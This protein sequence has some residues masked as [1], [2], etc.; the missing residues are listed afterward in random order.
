MPNPEPTQPCLLTIGTCNRRA[1]ITVLVESFLKHHPSAR[2]FVCLVDRPNSSEKPIGVPA[3][4][5]YADE[6]ALPAGR[7]FLFKYPAF[8][9]CCALKPYAMTHVMERF[10]ISQLLYLDS[11]ILVTAPF[12]DDLQQS[13]AN[14]A[15]LLTPH[16]VRLPLDVST[17]FQRSVAQ[18]G[19][20]NG[21][22][23]ALKQGPDTRRFLDGWEKLLE[24][25]CTFD[26]MNNVYVDQRWL[27]LL[28]ASSSAVGILRDPGLNVGYWNLHER[29]LERGL[30]G[31]WV[32]NHQPLKFFHFS[33]FARDRLT[34]K[35]SCSDQNAITLGHEYGRLL[36]ES[37]DQRCSELPYGWDFYCDGSPILLAHRD[38]ILSDNPQLK[39][40]A[41]P[42]VLPTMMNDWTAVQSLMGTATPVRVG[43]R[44]REREKAADILQRLHRH[45]VLGFI[46][47]FWYRFVNPSL[48]PD[49]P[50]YDRS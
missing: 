27:D 19:V 16:W 30:N 37:G 1:G 44:Y 8:E 4:V 24:S 2:V 7:R 33:G 9:L 46:W 32:A 23:V 14:H 17:E 41:N 10:T 12:W 15:I 31:A 13:W 25:Q 40:V 18:H 35:M 50:G 42:F 49:L 22:F 29:Q 28:A 47:K 48:R 45:P 36:D 11:D 26:P 5:F 39:H 38:L 34:H 43:Q 6:L 20:Y 3:S 21:G